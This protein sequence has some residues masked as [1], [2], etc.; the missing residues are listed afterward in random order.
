MDRCGRCGTGELQGL[1]LDDSMEVAGHTF[2]AQLPARRC[3]KCQ[4]I[5]VDARDLRE[6]ER[7]VCLLLARSGQQSGAVVKALRK[8]LSLSNTRLAEL[9]DVPA[10]AVLAWE[11]G[12]LEVPPHAAATLRSLVLT[13]LGEPA[14][15]HDAFALL[16]RPQALGKRIRLHL[17]RTLDSVTAGLAAKLA[18]A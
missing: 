4:D 6:F 18:T 14:I 17:R 9:L 16:R 12:G 10:E 13:H 3:P 5:L 15:S 1:H 2:T 7:A 11:D 8:S